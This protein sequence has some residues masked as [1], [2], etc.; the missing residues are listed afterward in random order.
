METKH[1][2]YAKTKACLEADDL[3]GVV[4]EMKSSVLLALENFESTGL[5]KNFRFTTIFECHGSLYVKM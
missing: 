2:F 5:F 3:R 4:D 1:G